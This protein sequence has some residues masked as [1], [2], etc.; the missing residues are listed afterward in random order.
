MSL[1]SFWLKF[2][3]IFM[4]LPHFFAS[5]LSVAGRSTCRWCWCPCP[6]L[7]PCRAESVPLWENREPPRGRSPLRCP[8][9]SGWSP[10]SLRRWFAMRDRPQAPFLHQIQIYLF[11]KVNASYLCGKQGLHQGQLSLGAVYSQ[12]LVEIYASL[13]LYTPVNMAAS[14]NNSAVR[15]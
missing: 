11:I 12:A 7:G 4:R 3:S 9:G 10:A 8:C 15:K 5:S 6:P 14:R 2:K 13:E 1:K